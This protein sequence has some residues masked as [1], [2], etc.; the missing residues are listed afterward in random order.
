MPSQLKQ[1]NPWFS[2]CTDAL[3]T[4]YDPPSALTVATALAP[5]PI[6]PGNPNDPPLKPA[7]SPTMNPGARQTVGVKP[8]IAV[9]ASVPTVDQPKVTTYAT[10]APPKEG[11]TDAG[12]QPNDSTNQESSPLQTGSNAVAS[13]GDPKASNDPQQSSDPGKGNDPSQGNNPKQAS[14]SSGD[15]GQG[16]DKP[17]SSPS[18]VNSDQGSEKNAD[19]VLQYD[20]KQTNNAIPFD[21]F[22]KG[23]AKTV[24]NQ[25]IQP[26]SNGISI[27]DTTLTTGAP[28]I[29][30]SG[31]PIYLGS[32]ALVIGTS[33]VPL[34]SGTPTQITTTIAGHVITAAP[35]AIAVAGTTLTRGAPPIT[36]SGTPIHF[37]SSALVIG[38]STVHFA[39]E[40]PTQMITTIAGHAVTAAPNGIAVAGTTL[41]P[42]A[43]GTT[44]DGTLLSLDTASQLIIGSKTI[45]LESASPSSRTTTIGGQVITA[46][47]NGIVI[48]GTTLTP[49]ASGV[50]VGGTLVSLN[51]A[52][53]LVV[54]SKT[55]AL[56]SGG[57]GLGGLIMGGFDIGASSKL[58]DPLTTTIDGHVITAGPTAVAMAGT[59]LTPG[60]PGFTV[61]GTLVSLNAAAQL[62]VGSK[63]IALDSENAG[64]SSGT[65]GLGGLI[66][67]GLGAGGPFGAFSTGSPSSTQG[68]G[69]RVAGNGTSAGVLVF[70]GN[71]VSLKD[72]FLWGKI[73]VS[74]IAMSV[75]AYVC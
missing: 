24:N 51:T 62:V 7:S 18:Q 46:A 15:S 25:V 52:G 43:P 35:D 23:Q 41:S 36:V 3:F 57:T 45:P 19:P 67:G 66:M 59:T 42:G 44:L 72:H 16:V 56:P 30:V 32:S 63:T 6:S 27:A 22:T 58:A 5:P 31:T 48:A 47:P 39:P 71:A 49:A 50:M 20:P 1:M 69:S 8:S 9:P 54:G 13:N 2:F 37:G 65:A 12:S 33:T 40:V 55:I 10:P 70:S 11:D 17:N 38:T 53:Q 64:S 28:P 14:G 73:A 60:A 34:A 74:V 61:D 21:D 75:L 68:N 4:A 29:T 26:L